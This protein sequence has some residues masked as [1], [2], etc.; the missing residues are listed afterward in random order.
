MW[1]KCSCGNPI[2][3]IT[4]NIPYKARFIPDKLW[5]GMLDEICAGVE[6]GLPKEELTELIYDKIYDNSKD[7][8]QCMEC[9]RIYIEDK[10]VSFAVFE[11]EKIFDG[12]VIFNTE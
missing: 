5:F 4:D 8:Y 1:I 12:N 9:G 7:M 11:P 10:D 6:K 3:D 2:H